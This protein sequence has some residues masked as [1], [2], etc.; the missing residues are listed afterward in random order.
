MERKRIVRHGEMCG[1]SDRTR[2]NCACEVRR[3]RSIERQNY[4]G[5]NV[6]IK[7]FSGWVTMSFEEYLSKKESFKGWT[8][9]EVC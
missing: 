3:N 9:I 6:R 1:S 2:A 4:H 8:N 5:K 7:V